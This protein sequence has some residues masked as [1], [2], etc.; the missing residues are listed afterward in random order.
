M[1]PQYHLDQLRHGRVTLGDPA[2]KSHSGCL[3]DGVHP[4]HQLQ[5]ASAR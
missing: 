5:I 2:V 4:F 3:I 1:N